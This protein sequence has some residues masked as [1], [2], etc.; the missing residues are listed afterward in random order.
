MNYKCK[1][2]VCS[3]IKY[4]HSKEV[5]HGKGFVPSIVW[6]CDDCDKQFTVTI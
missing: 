5:K 6:L 2:P 3:E 4:L 1:C